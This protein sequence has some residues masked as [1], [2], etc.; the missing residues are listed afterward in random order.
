MLITIKKSNIKISSD[1]RLVVKRLSFEDK[2]LIALLT[3]L[4]IF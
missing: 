1:F 4:A 2:N 3:E